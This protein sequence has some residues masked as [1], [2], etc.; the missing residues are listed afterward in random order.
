MKRK[1]LLLTVLLLVFSLL[2]TACGEADT[3]DGTTTTSSTTAA[4]NGDSTTTSGEGDIT[5]TE[6]TTSTTESA[7]TTTTTNTQIQFPPVEKGTY[8]ASDI[9]MD[10]LQEGEVAE[11]ALW[12]PVF[13]D[14][15]CIS[16]WKE[17]YAVTETFSMK[18]IDC[19]M[20]YVRP[21]TENDGLVLCANQWADGGLYWDKAGVAF[22]SPGRCTAVLRGS[23]K[24][25]KIA[26]A[27]DIEA[28]AL[29][30]TEGRV[31]IYLNDELVWPKD[32]DFAI[33]TS[34]KSIDFPEIELDL[35]PGDVVTI[36]GYGAVP[37]EDI[38][39]NTNGTWE[40]HILLDPVIEIK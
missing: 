25:S 21:S 23:D 1:A 22:Y 27:T 17:M 15:N 28:N 6:S 36:V 18:T 12:K 14:A 30:K 11:D 2:L 37:G 3:T 40:N 34:K 35:Y 19:A 39:A 38:R 9:L 31:E 24:N 10:M 4:D 32:A 8:R 5:T 16:G 13:L 26:A 7:T 33:V 20:P 29:T